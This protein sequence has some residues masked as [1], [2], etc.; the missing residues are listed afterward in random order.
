M[1]TTNNG[2]YKY[3]LIALGAMLLV[4]IVIRMRKKGGGSTTGEKKPGTTGTTGTSSAKI[5]PNGKKCP[6]YPNSKALRNN[7]PGNLRIG[8]AAWQGKIPKA[9]N[10]DGAFEQFETWQYGL[11]AMTK[12][13]I[14]YINGGHNTINKIINRYAPS[15][16][17][18][19]NQYIAFLVKRTG[20]FSNKIL[21]P[22]D[23]TV[24][25]R[26][27]KGM[28][29]METGCDLVTDSEFNKAWDSI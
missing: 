8:S 21:D 13:I 26:L 5:Q 25:R 27:I 12:L 6:K 17:N 15:I 22:G 16:E 19:T 24:I 28:V 18:H 3:G 7:N 4:F 14:N 10:T 1:S 11:R 29:E 20:V 9:Q 2:L 23:K